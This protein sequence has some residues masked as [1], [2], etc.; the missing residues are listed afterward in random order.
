MLCPYSVL[1]V[2]H[3]YKVKNGFHT[4][5]YKFEMLTKLDSLTMGILC[6][7]T[8]IIFLISRSFSRKSNPQ[9]PV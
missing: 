6:Y 8:P 5:I 4:I 3:F 9:N 2:A 1:G 7:F